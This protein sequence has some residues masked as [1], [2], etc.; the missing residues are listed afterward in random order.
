MGERKEGGVG[1]VEE[2]GED[3][4]GKMGEGMRKMERGEERDGGKNKGV[5]G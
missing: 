3:G 2:G 5:R 4:M 1:S